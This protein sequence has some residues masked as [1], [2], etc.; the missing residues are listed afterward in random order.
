MDVRTW[1]CYRNVDR[2][3]SVEGLFALIRGPKLVG[4][5]V[6]LKAEISFVR[7]DGKW[8][9]GEV[10]IARHCQTWCVFV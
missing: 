3:L 1:K 5:E 2:Q 10:N 6:R 8:K 9:E 7:M 4:V